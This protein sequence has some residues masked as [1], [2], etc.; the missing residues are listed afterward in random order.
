MSSA[1][2]PSLGENLLESCLRGTQKGV[3]WIE[4]NEHIGVEEDV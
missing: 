3:A 2:C 4:R 1:G